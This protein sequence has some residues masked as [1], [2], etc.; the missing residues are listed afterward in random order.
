M[1]G[2]ALGLVGGLLIAKVAHRRRRWMRYAGEGGCGGR[3]A[4][5]RQRGESPMVGRDAGQRV[6]EALSKLELNQRQAEESRDVFAR[7]AQVLGADYRNWARVDLAFSAAAGGEFDREAAAA[8]LEVPGALGQEL[9]DGLEH[10]HTILTSEQRAKL[11][12][13][14]RPTSV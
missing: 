1:T 12:E 3:H 4:R 2:I 8:A 6:I 7:I 5:W 11:A 10:F 14:I 13:V 9:V